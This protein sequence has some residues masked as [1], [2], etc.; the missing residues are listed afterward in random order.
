MSIPEE[1]RKRVRAQAGNRCGYCRSPQHLVL[2][3]LEIEHITCKATGRSD[4]ED[5]LWLA[6]RLCNSYKGT[7]ADGLDPETRLRVP[8]FNPRLQKWSDHFSWSDDG[9]RVLGRTPCGRVIVIAL[10][11]NNLISVMVRREWVAAGW[12]PPHEPP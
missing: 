5:N 12:H 10:Q 6:C 2:G 7:Q 8:L 9:T 4:D 3:M 1:T 11:M